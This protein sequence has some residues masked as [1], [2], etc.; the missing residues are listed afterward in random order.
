MDDPTETFIVGANVEYLDVVLP[1]TSNIRIVRATNPQVSLV[2]FSGHRLVKDVTTL[3]Q[4]GRRL[5]L[6]LEKNIDTM[7]L[8]T[9]VE[10][11]LPSHVTLEIDCPQFTSVDIAN[12]VE[13]KEIKF[14]DIGG[15][16]IVINHGKIHLLKGYV[17]GDMT[18]ISSGVVGDLTELNVQ[19]VCDL[20]VASIISTETRITAKKGFKLIA[21]MTKVDRLAVRTEGP[22]EVTLRS[23]Y[24]SAYYRN[25]HLVDRIA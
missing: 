20:K 16:L 18:L 25:G 19:G 1:G 12:G 9:E 2:T 4:G 5:R 7:L 6:D 8:I 13:I 24:L 14:S 15:N 22:S 10:I 17:H 23:G 21:E 3:W 11:Q